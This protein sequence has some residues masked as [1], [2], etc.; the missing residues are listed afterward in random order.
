L[1]TAYLN[2]RY[3]VPERREAFTKGL[4]KLGFKVNHCLPVTSN[5]GDIFVTWNRIGRANDIANDYQSKGLPVLVSEN[6]AW[7][8]D[9]A[10]QSWYA[11]ARNY[12]NT[13]GCFNIGGTERWDDLGVDIKPFKKQDGII[14]LPQR[15]IGS[16]P[17]VM[18]ANWTA[19]VHAKYGGLI[20]YHPGRARNPIPLEYDLNRHGTAI[21]WGSGAAVKALMMGLHVKSDMPNW[22]AAQDN[23]EQGRLDMFRRLAWAQWRMGE[24]QNGSAFS[25]LLS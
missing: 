8:N 15:G 20:R 14:I 12:H 16:A 17:T 18:P 1:K 7:G 4:E 25:W 21:T 11:I 2:L 5:N 24:I 19:K 3:T 22:I 9:L 23:T 10:G 13:A 6:S